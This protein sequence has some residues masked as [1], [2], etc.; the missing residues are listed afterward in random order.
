[1]DLCFSHNS[2]PLYSLSFLLPFFFLS[3]EDFPHSCPRDAAM[4]GVRTWLQFGF[5]KAMSHAGLLPPHSGVFA[6]TCVRLDLL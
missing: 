5:S 2:L 3:S 6:P 4:S 1:M